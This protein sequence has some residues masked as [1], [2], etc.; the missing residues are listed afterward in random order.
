[1][2]RKVYLPRKGYHVM[3]TQRENLN[4]LDDYELIVV[5]VEHCTIDQIP[6]VLLVAFGEE[7]HSL[8]KPIRR[9]SKA[10]SLRIFANA[11]EYGSNSACQFL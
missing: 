11:L 9:P 10:F 7:K 8:C 5:L 2:A 3:F 4:V 1:M 6:D